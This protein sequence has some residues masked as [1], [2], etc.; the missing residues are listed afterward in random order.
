M[1]PIIH[2]DIILQ[3]QTNKLRQEKKRTGIQIGNENRKFCLFTGDMI[4]YEETLK[5]LRKIKNKHTP[6]PKNSRS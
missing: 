5:E 1:L 6:K 2:I 3:V 4:I